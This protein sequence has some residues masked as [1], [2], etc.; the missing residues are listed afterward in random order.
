M[1]ITRLLLDSPDILR[2][3]YLDIFLIL[4]LLEKTVQVSWHIKHMAAEMPIIRGKQNYLKI[5]I[6]ISN[7]PNRVVTSTFMLESSKGR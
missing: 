4:R 7:L 2:H 6:K 1:L 5:S 3:A